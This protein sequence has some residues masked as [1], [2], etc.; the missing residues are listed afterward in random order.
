MAGYNATLKGGQKLYI[1]NWSATVALGNLT[2]LGN[3]ID[4]DPI[5]EIAKLNVVTSM[6]SIIESKDQVGVSALVKHFVMTAKFDGNK[7]S[8]ENFDALFDSNLYLMVEIFTH[9][10]SSQYKDFFALG[11][12]EENSQ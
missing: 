2:K 10:V 6:V 4:T 5:G 8:D 9:V 11:L 3:Y 7:I 12:A 1:P